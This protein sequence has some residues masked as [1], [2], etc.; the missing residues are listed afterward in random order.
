VTEVAERIQAV[1]EGRP[2]VPA[3]PHT[4]A[5]QRLKEALSGDRGKDQ[6]RIALV[7]LQWLDTLLR[8]NAD[9]G[10]SA[11]KRPKLAPHLSVGDAILA[12]MSDKVERIESLSGKSAEVAESLTDTM[13]DLGS[14]ALL[15][16]ARPA[17]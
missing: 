2:N 8:K 3:N 15:W 1:D 4:I 6:Q 16:L 17:E 12:R 11:W 7:G 10:S 13:N 5:I 9:Y 14:Y